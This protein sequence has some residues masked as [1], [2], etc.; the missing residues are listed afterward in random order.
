MFHECTKHIA[1]RY[2]FIRE[3]LEEG[4][5]CVEYVPMNYQVAEVLMK[6]L[7]REKHGQFVEGMGV[8]NSNR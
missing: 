2:H 4:K 8:V 5:I 6:P 1:I 7:A 3:T